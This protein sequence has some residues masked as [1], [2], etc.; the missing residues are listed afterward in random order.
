M[1]H[2]ALV[3]IVELLLQVENHASCNFSFVHAQKQFLSLPLH[4][5][6]IYVCDNNDDYGDL[7]FHECK[8]TC[9]SFLGAASAWY[10]FLVEKAAYLSDLRGTWPY[11]GCKMHELLWK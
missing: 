9:F 1:W 7:Q 8:S 6:N 10:F 5:L 4:P 3:G 2:G 11:F